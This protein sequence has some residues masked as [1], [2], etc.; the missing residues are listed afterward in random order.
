MAA[1]ENI[2][3]QFLRQRI[4]PMRTFA[5]NECVH[6]LSNSLLDA[7]ARTAGDDTDT[8][9]SFLATRN[10]QWLRAQ[11][12]AQAMLQIRAGNFLMRLKTNRSPVAGKK[13]PQMF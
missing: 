8:F 4:S 13:R 2:H 10:Q 1:I 6:V 5:G 12:T 3:A 11:R 7:I 9:A